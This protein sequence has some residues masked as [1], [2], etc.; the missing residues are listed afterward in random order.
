MVLVQALE[1]TSLAFVGHYWGEL[2]HTSNQKH[3]F[4]KT[5]KVHF[6]I[7]NTQAIKIFRQ[8]DLFLC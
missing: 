7:P 1:A 2:K 8:E 5:F 6:H 3:G 4:G